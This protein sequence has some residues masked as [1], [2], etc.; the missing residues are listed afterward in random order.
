MAGDA[1]NAAIPMAGKIAFGFVL[2][3]K[4]QVLGFSSCP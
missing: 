4:P 1:S 3:F 2:M